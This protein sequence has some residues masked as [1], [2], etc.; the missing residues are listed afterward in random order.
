MARVVVVGAGQAGLAASREL[1]RA[2]VEHVVLERGR[3]GATWRGRW[4][5][6]C[7]VTPNWSVRLPGHG[8]DGDDPDGYM[9]RDEIVAYLERYA[10]AVGAPVREGVAVTAIDRAGDGALAL[11][12]SEGAM[13]SDA[14]V[15]A[16]GAYQRPHR[17]AAAAALPPDLLQL[18]VE[19][20]RNPDALPAGPVLIVGSGQ[21]GCQIAEE[22]HEAGRDVF[23]ACGRTPWGSRRIGDRDLIW[24]ALETGYLDAPVESLPDPRARLLGNILA[25]GHDGGHDL[26]LRTLHAMGV[27]LLGH[28]LG[29]DGRRARFAP[30]LAESV[31]W[32]D[33]RHRQFMTL[34]RTLVAERG[35]TQPD[36]AEA[37]PLA[38]DAPEELDL[39]GFGAVIFA[40]GFRPDYG[41]WVRFPEAFDD[42][43]FP[44]QA[45][46]ASTVVDGLFFVGVHFLRKRKSSLL[47]GVAEDAE[48]VARS[49]A[50]RAARAA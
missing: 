20:Y 17:P 19:D 22:L 32:G 45:D 49:V 33:E 46:G 24:W 25:T 28:Y 37:A 9:A 50:T 5:G 18:D 2:G 38:C 30:D 16:S 21:S 8:Y 13:E 42:L 4:D 15:L 26:H 41:T 35:L 29:A 14:V 40:T 31:A 11:Q 6:F 48:I 1:T 34:V 12:T 47:L 3:V 23:V 44:I 10:A 43:G 39:A 36:V 7:L 27:T